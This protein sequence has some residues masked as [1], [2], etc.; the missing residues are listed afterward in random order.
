[1]MK[2]LLDGE[3]LPD[4][5]TLREGLR[6]AIQHADARGR[7]IVEALGDGTPLTE[8]QLTTP[9]QS[10]A[11]PGELRLRS[12]DPRPLVARTLREGSE[13]LARVRAEQERSAAALQEGRLEDAL[14]TLRNVL[15]AWQTVRQ[16]LEGSMGV[17]RIDLGAV[18]VT[19]VRRGARER[20]SAA[21]RAEAL[22]E[23]LRKARAHVQ[24]EDWSALA[25]LVG[26]DLDVESRAWEGMFGELA[27][28]IERGG[29]P[30]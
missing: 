14:E 13:L 22:A 21:Q 3:P 24:S 25:D 12:A 19:I 16:M 11:P 5:A 6:S 28:L 9:D 17:L 2:V 10:G 29:G 18:E 1:M 4:A 7:I 27:T 23:L 20:S 15:S 30:R 26:F 8:E